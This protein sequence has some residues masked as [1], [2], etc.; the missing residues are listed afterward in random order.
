MK[1]LEK[2]KKL[3][4][5]HPLTTQQKLTSC[6]YKALKFISKEFSTALITFDDGKGSSA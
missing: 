5:P 3:E 1:L 6:I 4:A 2:K